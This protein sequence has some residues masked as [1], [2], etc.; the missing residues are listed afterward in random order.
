MMRNKI[1]LLLALLVIGIFGGYLFL[2]KSDSG[3]VSPLSVVT[4]NLEKPL[5]R[6]GLAR[7][8]EENFAGGKIV[9][10]EVITE[11]DEYISYK[12]SYEVEGKRVTGQINIPTQEMPELGYPVIIMV[13]GY[14]DPETYKTGDGTR[15]AAAYF[16]SSGYIT[17]APDFLGYGD[18]DQEDENSF[19]AR[20]KRPVA[21]LELLASIDSVENANEDKIF[22]WAHSNGG[23]IALSVLEIIGQSQQWNQ[24]MIPTVLWAPVGKPFPYSILYYTDEYADG[25]KA[26][27]RAL[28]KFE[29]DYDVDLFSIHTYYDWIS[30]PIQV[31]QGTVDDAIPIEWSDDLVEQ[32]GALDKEITYFVYQGAD[33]DLRPTWD[34]VVSR[35]LLFFNGFLFD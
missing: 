2:V 19:S 1:W 7:L 20:V 18:S 10:E 6:Y 21:I 15:N 31:H 33:H 23:Q 26:L 12:F 5:D 27:R 17:L 30:S 35:N 4:Q 16:A 25:G 8:A 28:A 32:L 11:E 34:T 9:I 29:E 3:I 24:R 22:I 14:I 13:R